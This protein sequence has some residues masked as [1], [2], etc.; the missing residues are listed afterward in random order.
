MSK[1]AIVLAAGKGTRMKSEMSKLLHPIIDRPML[2]YTLEA[3][4][5]VGA[6]RVVIIDGYQASQVEEAFQ[7]REFALQ[8][9]QLGTGHA[10]MQAQSLKDEKGYTLVINGDGPCIQPETLNRLYEAAQGTAL[11]LM[12]CVFEEGARYGRI[13]RDENGE[14]LA[15]REAK[16]CTEEEKKI[17]E[18]NA[19]VYCFNNEDLFDSLQDLT[20][21]NAQNEYYLTDLVEILKSRGK[22]VQA[23]PIEDPDELQGI[24]DP[25]ELHQAYTW[26]RDRI[27]TGWMK[28][29]VQIVDP[30][31]TVIGK[32]VKIGHDV[33]IYPNT[34]ILGSTV[35][36]DYAEILPGSYL[37]DAFIQEGE[38]V[39]PNEIRMSGK[40]R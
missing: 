38:V 6:D 10:V 11:T 35:I 20:S 12:S 23:I 40:N 14:F 29:G 8:E 22:K 28:N 18:I 39:G 32:D 9:P 16:D 34:E 21:A 13:L 17:N 5:A 4:D 24:N 3:I 37:K 27:N 30:Q 33:I 25:I 7:G 36:S 15:I 19:G 2:A 31:R 26:I 1:N